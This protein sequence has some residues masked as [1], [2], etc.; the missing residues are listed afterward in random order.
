[1]FRVA[2]DENSRKCLKL[3]V[4]HFKVDPDEPDIVCYNIIM[5]TCWHVY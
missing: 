5:F 1:M 3:L 4:Y 2:A